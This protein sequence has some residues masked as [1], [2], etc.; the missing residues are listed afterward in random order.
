M[1]SAPFTSPSRV[2]AAT[3]PS[4]P[5][6]TSAIKYVS[7]RGCSKNGY[8]FFSP[9]HSPAQ[10]KIGARNTKGVSFRGVP[11]GPTRHETAPPPRQ[12]HFCHLRRFIQP[13]WGKKAQHRLHPRR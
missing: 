12:H 9:L 3:T 13:G 2:T 11:S 4:K 8:A 7:A 6:D 5:F 1:P 10:V